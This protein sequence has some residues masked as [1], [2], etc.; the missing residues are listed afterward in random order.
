MFRWVLTIG[1]NTISHSLLRYDLIT[2]EQSLQRMQ[3]MA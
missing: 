1:K 3:K 2:Q